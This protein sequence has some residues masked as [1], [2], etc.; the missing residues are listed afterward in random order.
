MSDD[1]QALLPFEDEGRLIRRQW[2]EDRWYFSVVDVVER[3]TCYVHTEL[4]RG[5]SGLRDCSGRAK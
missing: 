2:Y 4:A 5:D 1:T 3:R